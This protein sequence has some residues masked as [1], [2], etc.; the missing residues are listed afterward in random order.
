MCVEVCVC[1]CGRK[2]SKEISNFAYFP[3]Y[4]YNVIVLLEISK[5]K[6]LR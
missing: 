3:K 4:E 5:T 1:V 6:L 2:N